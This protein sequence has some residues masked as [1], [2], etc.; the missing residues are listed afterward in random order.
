LEKK[1]KL[2]QA[3]RLPARRTIAQARA[4]GIHRPRFGGKAEA[5]GIILAAIALNTNTST[6]SCFPEKAA[7]QKNLCAAYPKI[8]NLAI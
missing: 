8:P 7:S 3:P 1:S 4:T 5:P 2:L 6:R